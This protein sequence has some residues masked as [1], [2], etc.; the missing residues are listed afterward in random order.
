MPPEL[1]RYRKY[2]DPFD[3][4]EAQKIELTHIV[5]HMMESF[6]ERGFRSD[7]T[8]ICMGGLVSKGASAAGDMIDLEKSEYQ[9]LSQSFN[10]KKG[11]L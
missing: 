11:E 9:D 3:L 10:D 7:P 1:E 2:V 5:R 8:Q 6:V 4:T